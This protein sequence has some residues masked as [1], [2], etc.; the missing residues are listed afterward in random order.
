MILKCGTFVLQ[1]VL[2]S[3]FS[4]APCVIMRLYFETMQLF[5][6]RHGPAQSLALQVMIDYIDKFHLGISMYACIN[7]RHNVLN[8]DEVDSYY[9][10]KCKKSEFS[11][12][13]DQMNGN[14]SYN[15]ALI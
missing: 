12:N 5:F 13:A 9:N 11:R 7:M 8:D 6:Y 4:N 14:V 2:K 15:T 3:D 10:L 1:L